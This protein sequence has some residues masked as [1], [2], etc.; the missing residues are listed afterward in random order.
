MDI[1]YI[2]DYR[3]RI[4]AMGCQNGYVK[5]VLFNVESRGKL[6]F[7]FLFFVEDRTCGIPILLIV[8]WGVFGTQR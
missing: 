4:T 1:K 5:L 7:Y 6:L 2:D 8:F 3:R